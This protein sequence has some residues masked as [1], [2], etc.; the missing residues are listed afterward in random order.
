M[1]S[2]IEYLDLWHDWGLRF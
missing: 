2:G 1:N